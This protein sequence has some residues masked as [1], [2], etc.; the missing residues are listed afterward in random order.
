MHTHTHTHAHTQPTLTPSHPHTRSPH[1]WELEGLTTLMNCPTRLASLLSSADTG[2]ESKKQRFGRW[3]KTYSLRGRE[4]SSCNN[5]A[6]ECKTHLIASRMIVQ[7]GRWR[8]VMANGMM[9][10]QM[11]TQKPLHSLRTTTA[12]STVWAWSQLTACLLPMCVCVTSCHLPLHNTM[13]LS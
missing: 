1:T 7:N 10:Q 12:P 6:A 8:S 3:Y 11:K 9:S 5:T 13:L 4:I 2:L